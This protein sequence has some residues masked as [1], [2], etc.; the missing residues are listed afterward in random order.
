MDKDQREQVREMLHDVLSG[1]HAKVDAQNTIT[2][3]A[4]IR[5]DKKFEKL[6]GS[7]AENRKVINEN[8]PHTI[9]KC[10]QTE[11]I[12]SLKVNMISGKAIKTAIIS[13]VGVTGTLF[14]I[15]FILYKLITNSL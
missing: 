11:V 13:S 12:E 10:P 6:N 9:D 1:Y 3:D 8:L 14:A 15:F 5:I 7:V 4:L 2:N